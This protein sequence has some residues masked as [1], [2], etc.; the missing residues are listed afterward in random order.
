MYV[1]EVS[2]ETNFHANG[3]L[4]SVRLFERIGDAIRNPHHLKSSDRLSLFFG[5]DD[6]GK[7]VGSYDI[8]QT[9]LIAKVAVESPARFFS[10]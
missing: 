2:D 9:A 3:F 5:D 8:V 4:N 10:F 1:V 7:A 6:D